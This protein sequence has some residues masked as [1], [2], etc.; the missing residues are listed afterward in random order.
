LKGIT[1]PEI[2]IQFIADLVTNIQSQY[3]IDPDR[4]FAS[5]FS[6]GGGLAYLLSCNLGDRIAAI[7]C[8]S[9]AYF[10]PLDKCNH[11]NPVP[12]ILFHGTAD[13]VV[14]YHGGPSGPYIMPFPDI[15]NWVAAY[16]K[17]NQCDPSPENLTSPSENVTAVRFSGHKNRAEVQFYTILGGGHS[18]PGGNPLPR[19]IVGE[20]SREVDAT[21]LMWEFFKAHPL[22]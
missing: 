22:H 9:G 6:N 13:K 2:D 4:I 15:P 11:P 17:L 5:G 21:S 3:N 16:A 18:W 7:G 10:I 1:N 12:L 19:W 8:I 14:P 20:T